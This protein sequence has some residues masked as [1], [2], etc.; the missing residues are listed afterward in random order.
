MTWFVSG[1]RT[2]VRFGV[3]EA[4]SFEIYGDGQ[5][6]FTHPANTF[7]SSSLLSKIS[8]APASWSIHSAEAPEIEIDG[9]R[10]GLYERVMSSPEL[11]HGS[12]Q[13]FSDSPCLLGVTLVLPPTHFAQALRLFDI[14]LT[15]HLEFL[16]SMEFLGFRAAESQADAPTVEEFVGGRVHFF[17]DISLT[18]KWG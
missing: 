13:F 14:V 1:K 18:A 15:H 3:S 5:H 8:A 17:N 16:F 7:P 12:I 6:K 2:D 11:T 9:V 10:T 4:G